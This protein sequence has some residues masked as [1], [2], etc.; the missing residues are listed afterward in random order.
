[1]KYFFG[2][3]MNTIVLNDYQRGIELA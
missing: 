1:M 2:D 3:K